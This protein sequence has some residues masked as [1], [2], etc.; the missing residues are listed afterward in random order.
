MSKRHWQGKE[1]DFY[2]IINAMQKLTSKQLLQGKE[3]NLQ[4]GE[5]Y[6]LEVRKKIVTW[7]M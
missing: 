6:N 1:T 5:N 2:K 7:K 4:K 3:T